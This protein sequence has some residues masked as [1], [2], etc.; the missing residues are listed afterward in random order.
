MPAGCER[1]GVQ[2]EGVVRLREPLVQPVVEHHP[3]PGDD[4]LGRLGDEHHRAGPLVLHR[5]QHA[6]GA[7][8]AGHVDVV[9]AGVHHADLVAVW[10]FIFTLLA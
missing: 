5:R 8:P 7:D 4:L 9:P 1:I 6:G 2:G 10:S 3:R